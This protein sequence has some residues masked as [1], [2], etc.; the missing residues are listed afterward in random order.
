MCPRKE[1]KSLKG[2]K[3]SPTFNSLLIRKKK[4]CDSTFR[5]VLQLLMWMLLFPSLYFRDA[6]VPRL[7]S[8][9]K[10]EHWQHMQSD[11]NSSQSGNE[12]TLVVIS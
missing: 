9:N 11:R 5:V 1:R 12:C 8:P 3:K 7:V 2:K 4:E 10:C 6:D